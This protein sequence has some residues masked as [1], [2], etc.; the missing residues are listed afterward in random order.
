MNSKFKL[1]A[2]SNIHIH[3]APDTFSLEDIET[4]TAKPYDRVIAFVF[5][6]EELTSYLKH[7]IANQLITEQGYL[8]LVY[9]KKG[10]QNVRN[11]H[12]SR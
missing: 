5:T 8:F 12:S 10:E 4:S 9:P 2:D 3:N 1:T 6:I 11:L 7:C